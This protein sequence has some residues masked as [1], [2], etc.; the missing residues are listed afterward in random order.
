MLCCSKRPVRRGKKGKKDVVT[1]EIKE[2]KSDIPG[3]CNPTKWV[4]SSAR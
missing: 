3:N 2:D 1:S 4:Q